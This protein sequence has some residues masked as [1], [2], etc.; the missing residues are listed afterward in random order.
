MNPLL[1]SI[2]EGWGWAIGT[3]TRVIAINSFGNVIVQTSKG[4]FYRIIP[5]N[6]EYVFL[7]DSEDALEKITRES[8]FAFDW[9]MKLLRD[10]AERAL[11]KLSTNECYHL[12]IP[13]T[14]GGA[15]DLTNIKKISIGEWLSFTGDVAYQIKDLPDGT[16]IKFEWI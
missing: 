5:E 7:C 3:P 14:L 2:E 13:A 6:L 8:E 16:Q 1:T 15:Y 10:Q 4:Q 9:D 12:V 11:G